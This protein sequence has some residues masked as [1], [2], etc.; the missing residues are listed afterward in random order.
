MPKRR[1]ESKEERLERK[2]N[3]YKK[4]Y[5]RCKRRKDEHSKENRNENDVGD[6]V[7]SIESEEEII[8]ENIEP[9]EEEEVEIMEVKEEHLE[10][11]IIE[12]MGPP[13]STESSYGQPIHPE[14]YKRVEG[15]LMEGLTKEKIVTYKKEQLIPEN[16]ILLEVPLLNPELHMIQ[17]SEK[18]RDKKIENRQ[19]LLGLATGT[20]LKCVDNLT[21]QNFNKLD[22]IKNMTEAARILAHLHS[23]DTVIR[24]NLL[25][26]YL[27]K[28]ISKTLADLRR[29]KLLF[30]EKLSECVKSATML[31]KSA[32]NLLKKSIPKPFKPRQNSTTKNYYP[33]QHQRTQR[34]M[35]RGNK[36]FNGRQPRSKHR[37]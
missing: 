16:T 33:P 23:E 28:T 34:K 17:E 21:K 31:Q 32:S 10:E 9:E 25:I 19:N 3:N 24:K 37:Q 5:E 6:I 27:D 7:E 1:R 36:I 11:D 26:P 12:A 35:F 18:T 29:D 20:I 15:I 14:I 13:I 30:G 8:L 4:K 2:L 22:I